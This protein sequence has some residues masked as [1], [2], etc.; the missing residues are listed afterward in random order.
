VRYRRCA[1]DVDARYGD[2]ISRSAAMDIDSLE[3]RRKPRRSSAAGGAHRGVQRIV[4]RTRCSGAHATERALGPWSGGALIGDRLL[5]A[6]SPS[7]A[8]RSPA[9]ELPEEPAT[10]RAPD[11]L[12]RWPVIP[13]TAAGRPPCPR[14][15]AGR[16]RRAAHDYHEI[17][18]PLDQRI[19]GWTGPS[20]CN[21]RTQTGAVLDA[22]HGAATRR[23]VRH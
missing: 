1:V 9:R 23:F 18:Q 13:A 19:A 10:G 12:S 7:C 4:L 5:K 3:R 16:R 22:R 21:P 17:R 11:A 2:G 15:T 6:A 14:P 20:S 8:R